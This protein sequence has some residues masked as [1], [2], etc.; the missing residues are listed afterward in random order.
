M[1]ADIHSHL[2]RGIDDG[3]STRFGLQEALSSLSCQGITH[4]ALTPHFYPTQDSL[5]R[6]CHRRQAAFEEFLTFP[7]AEAF[8]LS[9]GAEVYFTDTL[10]NYADLTPLCYAGTRLMLTELE[11]KS[12]FSVYT[13]KRLLRLIQE[14]QIV[15]VL[16][17]IDRYP[18]LYRDLGLLQHLSD[19]GCYFQVNFDAFSGWLS[20]RRMLGIFREGHSY[21]LGEDVHSLPME[22]EKKEQLL[23]AVKRKEDALFDTADQMAKKHIFVS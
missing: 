5:E 23:S 10:F 22:K 8:T 4:L 20:R 9:L 18:F 6:F 21:F 1:R 13:E 17:H 19:M 12:S 7:E 15:P 11:T 16:A 14:H 3:I 2:L